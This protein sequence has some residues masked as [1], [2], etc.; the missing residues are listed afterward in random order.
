MQSSKTSSFLAMIPWG[1][2]MILYML[3]VYYNQVPLEGTVGNIYIVCGIIVLV[4]EFV[5]SGEIQPFSF[6]LDQVFSIIAVVLS[7]YLMTI[8]YMKSG[9]FPNFY[10]LFGYAIIIGDSIFS[11]FN[12]YRMALRNF[13]M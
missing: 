1:F 2:L 13:S 5:K 8:L 3:F 7:T 10:Y 9:T 4:V 6:I 11:P 12:A